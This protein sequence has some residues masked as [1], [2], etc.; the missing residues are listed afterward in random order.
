MRCERCHRLQQV[1]SALLYNCQAGCQWRKLTNSFPLADGNWESCVEVGATGRFGAIL[2]AHLVA[3]YYTQA[4]TACARRGSP[5][6][7]AKG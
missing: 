3:Q 1:T 2:G 7:Q 4:A 5:R 6:L